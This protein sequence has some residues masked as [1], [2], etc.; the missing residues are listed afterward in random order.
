MVVIINAPESQ[1]KSVSL[2]NRMMIKNPEKKKRFKN[3]VMIKIVTDIRHI[4]IVT[5]IC[6]DL[7]QQAQPLQQNSV[8]G[9]F[10]EMPS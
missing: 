5:G 4:R 9:I 10:M 2:Y 1:N 7:D 6:H 3:R 8:E